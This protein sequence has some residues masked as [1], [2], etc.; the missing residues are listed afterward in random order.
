MTEW[1]S[2][3]AVIFRFTMPKIILPF[4]SEERSVVVPDWGTVRLKAFQIL[5]FVSITE[6]GYQR[7]PE[8]API[9]PALF[10]TGNSLCFT[11]SEAQL[12]A[13]TP[14][15][16]RMREL[17]K[18]YSIRQP[19]GETLPARAILADVWLH[20]YSCN[21]PPPRG[22][23]ASSSQSLMKLSLG[24]DGIACVPARP[25][26]RP[27]SAWR[28]TLQA[29]SDRLLGRRT[30]PEENRPERQMVVDRQ[31]NPKAERLALP[32]LPLLGLRA[33][34]LN[35]RRAVLVCNPQGGMFTI[36]PM[37]ERKPK[38]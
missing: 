17:K 30:G 10:D 9:V 33:F 37:A 8:S 13:A 28:G 25:R 5:V 27:P 19:G 31:R 22:R 3:P 7:V 23:D 38:A 24:Q 2:R 12:E 32:H 14:H 15:G 36:E 34:C 21:N 4:Y 26:S 20:D 6:Q 16:M 1:G 29:I 11:L 18:G 35:S